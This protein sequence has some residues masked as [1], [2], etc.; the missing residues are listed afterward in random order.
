[1]F[2]ELILHIIPDRLRLFRLHLHKV[3]ERGILVAQ[4]AIIHDMQ[5]P[6][7]RQ[8]ERVKRLDVEG[9]LVLPMLFL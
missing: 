7:V 3:A 4:D 6:Q 9:K 2:V 5:L 8:D 1:M